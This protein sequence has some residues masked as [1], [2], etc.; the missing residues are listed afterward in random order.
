[1]KT[2]LII[3]IVFTTIALVCMTITFI[4]LQKTERKVESLKA[5]CNKLITKKEQL[6]G[7][8]IKTDNTKGDK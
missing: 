1:M 4:E 3:N 2:L 7:M 8:N 5:R 6:R